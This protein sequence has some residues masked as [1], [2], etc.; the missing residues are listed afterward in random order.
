M[1]LLVELEIVDKGDQKR[2]GD[3]NNNGRRS[4][5]GTEHTMHTI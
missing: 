5:G 1:S 3:S 2:K 4:K